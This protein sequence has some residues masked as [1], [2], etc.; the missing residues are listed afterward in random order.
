MTTMSNSLDTTLA[1]RLAAYQRRL[2]RMTS[3][4]HDGLVEHVRTAE[5]DACD[6]LFDLRALAEDYG[7]LTNLEQQFGGLA[8]LRAVRDGVDDTADEGE[9]A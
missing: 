2:E 7:L 4:Y 1:L 5:L 8:E 3:D 6:D 9:A